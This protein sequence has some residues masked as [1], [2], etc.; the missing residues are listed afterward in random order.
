MVCIPRLKGRSQFWIDAGSNLC[1]TYVHFG[2]WLNITAILFEDLTIGRTAQRPNL[3]PGDLLFEQWR[4]EI[5]IALKVE[6]ATSPVLCL[7][8][9]EH[10]FFI[11]TDA[12][13]VVVGSYIGARLW[14]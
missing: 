14:F 11:T 8:Y 10:Q 7:P 4:R 1:I 2:D 13:D 9:F 12:S 3:W 6:M 5:F